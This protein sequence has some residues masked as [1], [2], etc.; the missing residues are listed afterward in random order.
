MC[1]GIWCSIQPS[2]GRVTDQ[3]CCGYESY[4]EPARQARRAIVHLIKAFS[5]FNYLPLSSASCESSVSMKITIRD[6]PAG[7]A[8]IL[9]DYNSRMAV[10]TDGR[11]LDRRLIDPGVA[12]A[13]ADRGKGRY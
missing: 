2:Y 4:Q 7:D 3:N 13:L 12:A 11:S 8:N 5:R 6:A 1:L 9:A 10:E